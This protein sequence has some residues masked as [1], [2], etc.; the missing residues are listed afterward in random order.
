MQ[1][2]RVKKPF[3]FLASTMA[4]LFFSEA[5]IS[6][7][8][9]AHPI[10]GEF[11][12]ELRQNIKYVIIIY[13]EN[14]SFDSLFGR[15]P[16]ANGLKQAAPENAVQVQP[17]GTPFATLPQPNTTVLAGSRQGPTL[18]FRRQSPIY[19]TISLRMFRLLIGTGT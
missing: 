17:N 10:A 16:G 1:L 7:Q 2:G 9:F 19:R 13:P 15:V 12:P 8:G 11:P 6:A 4:A 5:V 14:R 3:A 18:A